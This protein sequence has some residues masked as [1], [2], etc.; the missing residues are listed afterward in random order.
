MTQPETISYQQFVDLAMD[1]EV[2]EEKL[3]RYLRPVPSEGTAFRIRFEPDPDVVMMTDADVELENAM[4]IGNGAARW[5][6]GLRFLR[7]DHPVTLVSEGDSWFQFPILIDDVIDHLSD[8]FRIRSLGA[9]GDT[10]D[11]IIIGDG[12]YLRALADMK[13]EV[14]GFLLS[15]AG[16]DVLGQDA[17][18]QPVLSKL[19]KKGV[20]S[21]DPAEHLD[22]VAVEAMLARLEQLYGVAIDSIRATTGLERLPIFI[23]GYDYAIPGGFPGD[24][25]NPRHAKKDGWLGR[26][27]REAG[28]DDP[29]LQRAIVRPLVDRLNERFIAMAAARSDVHHVD[30]RGTLPDVGQWADEI[31]PTSEG[32]D[33]VAE[34][35]RSVISANVGAGV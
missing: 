28:I 7:S 6:R 26:P 31:H 10:A 14:D 9:A 23:H 30:V 34:K 11:N 29:G 15:A 19:L 16:N 2:T 24:P 17:A 25:R 27:L 5:R 13:G 18:G 35:F 3:A 4:S 20:S 22:P 33:L 32:F 8:H 21:D 1:P 12:E